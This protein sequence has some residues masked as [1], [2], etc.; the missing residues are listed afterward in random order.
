MHPQ[1]ASRLTDAD[2]GIAFSKLFIADQPRLRLVDDAV[3]PDHA[4]FASALAAVESERDTGPKS[5]AKDTL[6]LRH[7]DGGPAVEKGDAEGSRHQW[8]L[9][10]VITR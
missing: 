8:L 3:D 1:V 2:Q 5:G 6:I 4:G 10:A 7:L 9:T